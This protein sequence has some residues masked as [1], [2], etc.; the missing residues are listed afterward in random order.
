MPK[1]KSRLDELR[2]RVT[3]TAEY[4]SAAGIPRSQTEAGLN[5][6][7]TRKEVRMAEIQPMPLD[8]EVAAI[9]K[10][11]LEVNGK[12]VDALC[13]APKWLTAPDEWLMQKASVG[14]PYG[15]GEAIF[16]E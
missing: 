9:L 2:E 7:T 6:Y 15:A 3:G 13:A 1:S 8:P 10:Q 16:D 4:H 5:V 14:D 12:I 11:I